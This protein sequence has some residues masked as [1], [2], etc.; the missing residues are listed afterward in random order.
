MPR[1]TAELNKRSRKALRPKE[2]PTWWALFSKVVG[3]LI[4]AVMAWNL[5]TGSGGVPAKPS[6]V[7]VSVAPVQTNPMTSSAAVPPTVVVPQSTAPVVSPTA[8]PA[9]GVVDLPTYNGTTQSVKVEAVTTAENFAKG[10][11]GVVTGRTL[12]ALDASGYFIDVQVDPDGAGPAV[13]VV[14]QV[15]V[16]LAGQSWV[17]TK[18]N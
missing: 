4:I 14:M 16:V 6:S 2:T 7:S 5:M 15:R 9:D 3:G 10:V 12:R 1:I 18:V 11:G 8:A 13:V 17:A